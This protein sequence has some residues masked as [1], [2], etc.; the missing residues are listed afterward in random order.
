MRLKDFIKEF[1]ASRTG[2]DSLSAYYIDGRGNRQQLDLAT[3]KAR[4]PSKYGLILEADLVRHSIQESEG[5][6]WDGPSFKL[7]IWSA[8]LDADQAQIALGIH[9]AT[10]QTSQTRRKR[11]FTL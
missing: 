8:E 4:N 7:N 1:Q 9:P 6:Y 10:K 2:E 3:L 11:R 5:C